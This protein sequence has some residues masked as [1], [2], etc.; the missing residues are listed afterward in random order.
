MPGAAQGGFTNQAGAARVSGNG[1]NDA[2]GAAGFCEPSSLAQQSQGRRTCQAGEVAGQLLGHVSRGAQP[3]KGFRLI[4]VS[5]V[6][7]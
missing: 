6:D 7:L 4:R 2:S 5:A 1:K 3:R